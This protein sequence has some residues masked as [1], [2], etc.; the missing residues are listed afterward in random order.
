MESTS[1]WC[2]ILRDTAYRRGEDK[3]QKDI[4]LS[5]ILSNKSNSQIS[6]ILDDFYRCSDIEHLV[7]SYHCNVHLKRSCLFHYINRNTLVSHL[8]TYLLMIILSLTVQSNWFEIHQ[9][10][11]VYMSLLSLGISFLDSF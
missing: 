6:R 4:Y 9:V 3:S 10:S 1:D 11:P 2:F 7:G 8:E 5:G